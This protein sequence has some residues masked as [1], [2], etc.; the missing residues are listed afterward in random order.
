MFAS[1]LNY[2]EQ[3]AAYNSINFSFA[4]GGPNPPNSGATNRT[5]LIVRVASYVCPSD[6]LQVP[7]TAA[8]SN[9]AYSQTSYG[10][11][12]GNS[13]IL[14]YYNGCDKSPVSISP[15]GLF[16]PDYAFKIAD[17]TDG[18]SNTLAVGETS[19]FKNDP[20]QVFQ[21]WSRYA[22]FNSNLA[23]ASRNNALGM[24]TPAINAALMTPDVPPD[25]TYYEKWYLNASTSTGV[26]GMGQFGFR[27]QHPG[28]ANFLF[29]DGS[30]HF[31]KQT[32]QT[33]GPV[34]ANGQLALGVYR[35][36]ATKAGGEVVS[37]DSF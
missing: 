5:A 13:D 26:L 36:L 10:G 14:R 27:S 22:W 7:Y 23:G 19:R 9:N 31:L 25:P 12:S 3:T 11:V 33:V 34:V 24:C 1:L 2:M 35:K 32:I 8:Q 37:S 6:S 21:Q 16:G 29:A 4:S 20:D 18:T 28:G 30:V 17:I 15:D